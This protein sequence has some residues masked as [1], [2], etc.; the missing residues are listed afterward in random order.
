MTKTSVADSFASTPQTMEPVSHEV[1][2][3]NCGVY[4]LCAPLGLGGAD[5]SLLER[6]VRRK[7][8]YRRGEV[9][10]RSGQR[11][12]YL[13]AIRSGSVKTFLATE[14]GRVQITG[15]Q[16]PGELLGLSAIGPMS[17]TCE[18]IALEATSVC[19]VAVELLDEVAAQIPAIHQQLLRIMSHQIVH[20]EELMLLLGKRSA[21]ERLA[22][23]LLGLSRRF[24]KRNFSPTRFN[25]SMSRGDIGNYLGLA[26]ETV[27][28]LLARFQVQG[29]IAVRRRQVEL[30]DLGRLRAL[31]HKS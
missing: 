13:Y 7:Q 29:I 11:F 16:V 12:D 25:L 18:A 30:N 31:A 9:L 6:V 24:A 1:S 23:F 28:R 20:D 26:E 5:M 21:D 3:S 19:K 17:Y 22:A 2:C 4:Q 10:F 8:T 14:D 15:L 27:C